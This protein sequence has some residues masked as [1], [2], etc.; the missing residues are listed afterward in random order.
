MLLLFCFVLF[1]FVFFVCLL[2]FFFFFVVFFKFEKCQ[3]F[4]H[5]LSRTK[6]TFYIY[7]F[8]ECY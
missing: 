3:Y 1:C 4:H 6:V 5:N 8:T 2:F 7:L